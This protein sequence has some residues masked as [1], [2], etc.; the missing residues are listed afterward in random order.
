MARELARQPAA[1]EVGQLPL[2]LHVPGPQVVIGDVLRR[3]SRTVRARRVG[4]QEAC[5]ARARTA[6]ASAARAR[7]RTCTPL[8][9]P[10]IGWPATSSHVALAVSACRR[11]TAFAPLAWRRTNAVMSNGALRS[12]RAAAAELQQ[13]VGRHAACASSHGA[14]FLHHQAAVEGLVAGRDGR[15]D[16]EH[17]VPP[18]RRSASSAA[19]PGSASISSR[20]RSSS[21]NAEWP[22][23]RCQTGGVDAQLIA[24]P[25]RRQSPRISSW[26]R[27]ISRPRTYR[28]WVIG[29]S[30]PALA[31]RSVSSSRTG[32][33]P[34]CAT[35]TAACT[36]AVG[37][38]NAH[39]Q[40]RP[41]QARAPVAAAAC[42]GSMS[43]WACSWCPSASIC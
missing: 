33:R 38:V 27:R 19:R 37:E 35:Q 21:R 11:L 15:V 6:G 43:G 34:T 16:G 31:G 42:R 36:C 20:A 24:A 3:L 1:H 26:Q 7:W 18:T 13:L 10:L 28:M 22:S 39:L 32:T 5:R 25:A 9:M 23:F 40:G 12:S 17:R 41:V 14:R 29:R 4:G 2:L 30:G 8:V